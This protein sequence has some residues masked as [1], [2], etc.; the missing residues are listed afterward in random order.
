MTAAA[1]K[2]ALK[3]LTLDGASP[4][5][6]LDWT[7]PTQNADGT[8]TPGAWVSCR[9]GK[10]EYRRN[11]IH[12]AGCD[13]IGWWQ[14]HLRGRTLVTWVV[15]YDGQTSIGCHGFAARR[16]RLVRPWDGREEV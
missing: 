2:L 5:H 10:V 11:G 9:K 14:K 1:P 15:E 16:A 12:L 6:A 13:Q 3:A 7:L 8:W 4:V